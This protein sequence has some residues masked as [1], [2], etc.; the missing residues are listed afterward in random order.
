MEHGSAPVLLPYPSCLLAC[1][2]NRYEQTTR[3]ARTSGTAPVLGRC[4][5]AA[6]AFC[7]ALFSRGQLA[8]HPMSVPGQRDHGGLAG[9]TIGRDWRGFRP[10]DRLALA[11]WAVRGLTARMCSLG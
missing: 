2:C 8:T 6:L 10:R 9:P 7:P 4:S 3:V 1:L 11:R 5:A